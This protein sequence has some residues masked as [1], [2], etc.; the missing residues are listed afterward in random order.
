MQG[1]R[2]HM[3]NGPSGDSIS[4]LSKFPRFSFG[5]GPFPSG[6][7]DNHTGDV[8]AYDKD[9]RCWEPNCNIGMYRIATSG[10]PT[11][12]KVQVAPKHYAREDHYQKLDRPEAI[13]DCEDV[14]FVRNQF[15]QHY[16][17]K[18]LEAQEFVT[19]PMDEWHLNSEGALPTA[20]GMR[21][22]CCNAT[23]PVILALDY[24]L[25]VAIDMAAKSGVNII[26]TTVDNFVEY[27]INA[28]RSASARSAVNRSLF[29]HI[30]GD[31][32]LGGG[33]FDSLRDQK[34]KSPPLASR[35]IPTTLPK[36][37]TQ[38]DTPVYGMFFKEVDSGTFDLTA[39]V[40]PRTNT[41]VGRIGVNVLRDPQMN[42]SKRMSSILRDSGY[43]GL[44]AICTR[45]VNQLQEIEGAGSAFLDS[46]KAAM[47]GRI[48]H[49]NNIRERRTYIF[50][51]E[52][53]PKPAKPARGA[54]QGTTSF[55]LSSPPD[56]RNKARNS[57]P[58]ALDEVQIN[59]GVFNASLNS[60]KPLKVA[61]GSSSPP[62]DSTQEFP[63]LTQK[64][65]P[66]SA[67]E[68]RPSMS[69]FVPM[70]HPKVR[71]QSIAK[72]PVEPPKRKTI[73]F[74]DDDEDPAEKTPTRPRKDSARKFV[75]PS[76]TVYVAGPKSSTPAPSSSRHPS[77]SSTL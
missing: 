55:I 68:S 67:S 36:G 38:I 4:A 72:E 50:A 17:V 41:S 21:V 65:R 11:K 14:C 23:G 63:N 34:A 58:D 71:R 27:S 2:Y 43:K 60:P 25:I 77:L 61:A 56:A 8:Y 44:D 29:I 13:E 39:L 20:V 57:D 40:S 42:H 9:R 16:S 53:Q 45:A 69:S 64:H 28:L 26:R 51:A 5:S 35:K 46:T 37:P 59:A 30:F 22:I 52:E 18:N 74:V 33:K 31:H 15:L 19:C 3:L 66:S 7:L 32:G 1:C 6:W 24:M 76:R 49:T 73:Y 70:H 12:N 10:R 75:Q 62:K 48:I 47:A 54:V